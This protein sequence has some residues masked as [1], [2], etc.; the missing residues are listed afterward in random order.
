MDPA[1][2]GLAVGAGSG[3]AAM[4]TAV[5]GVGAVA[6]GTGRLGPNRTNHHNNTPPTGG[7]GV[8]TVGGDPLTPKPRPE[9]MDKRMAKEAQKRE[10]KER[11]REEKERK[12]EEK[13]RRKEG[14]GIVGVVPP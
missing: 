13:R 7:L 3:A 10:E 4:S 1:A 12:M 9:E 5:L 6:T 8:S 11:K 2:V 14:G